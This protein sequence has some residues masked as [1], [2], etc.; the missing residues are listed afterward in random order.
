MQQQR[1]HLRLPAWAAI[2][3]RS[4]R[5]PPGPSHGVT[6]NPANVKAPAPSSDRLP[7]RRRTAVVRPCALARSPM[8]A[9]PVLG[10]TSP[11][12]DMYFSSRSGPAQAALAPCRSQDRPPGVPAAWGQCPVLPG[13]DA[14]RAKARGKRVSRPSGTAGN[15][16]ARKCN[17]DRCEATIGAQPAHCPSAAVET[18]SSAG[19]QNRPICAATADH[20]AEAEA[21]PNGGSR[22]PG[23]PNPRDGA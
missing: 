20:E 22:S 13:A 23:S 8:G 1:R 14:A 16:G 21:A 15:G 3:R 5:G 12:T 10:P 7:A 18:K 6:R 19:V 11:L 17:R 4:A 2:V 9:G